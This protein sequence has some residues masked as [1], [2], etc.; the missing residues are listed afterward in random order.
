VDL[1]E[2]QLSDP[3]VTVDGNGKFYYTSLVVDLVSPSTPPDPDDQAGGV[4]LWEW[5]ATNKQFV[6]PVLVEAYFDG[7]RLCDKPWTYTTAG[8]DSFVTYIDL[9][10]PIGSGTF[11][12][13]IR[14][15]SAAGAVSG[16]VELVSDNDFKFT[17][18]VMRGYDP[19]TDDPILYVFWMNIPDSRI[20]GRR[21]DADVFDL[22]DAFEANDFSATT[23]I[24]LVN[25][26]DPV[27]G[28]NAIW[29]DAYRDAENDTNYVF[30]VFP[31]RHDGTHQPGSGAAD[32]DVFLVRST[33]GGSTWSTPLLVNDNED[34]TPSNTDNF[35]VTMDVAPN[36]RLDFLWFDRRNTTGNDV[37]IFYTSSAD[38]GSTRAAN[39][40]ITQSFAPLTGASCTGGGC[41][42]A[43][44]KIGEY[45][46]I[47]SENH[48]VILS[49]TTT[50]NGEQDVYSECHCVCLAK[51]D[52]DNDCDVYLTDFGAFQ[53]CYT[54]PGGPVAVG[55]E[56]AD[57]DDD[58]DVDLSDFGDFQLAFT[59]STGTYCTCPECE[60][61]SAGGGEPSFLELPDEFDTIL[62]WMEQQ[63]NTYAEAHGLLLEAD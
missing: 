43:S 4:F 28:E 62:D 38:F 22:M 10:N 32:T 59:G 27:I 61:E 29:A 56:W 51:G 35:F 45:H 42:S 58:D 24:F 40:Q 60:T 15:V 41:P 33:D 2:V 12:V 3:V 52:S 55:C 47:H 23:E 50:L 26:A 44:D 54:G 37:E 20:R 16:A 21:S 13:M 49:Y 25:A 17:P 53:L 7:S 9:K 19:S 18:H 48:H 34:G 14:R 31:S 57:F 36:G 8:G 6:N 5:D 1:D 63:L 30:V 46:Q 11:R 39:T